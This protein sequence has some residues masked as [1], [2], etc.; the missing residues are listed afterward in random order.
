MRH[1]SSFRYVAVV[2]ALALSACSNDDVF[3]GEGGLIG[4]GGTGGSGGGGGDGTATPE[5]RIGVL[6]GT[7]FTPGVIEVGQSPLAAGGSSGLRVNIVDTANG[8][9]LVTDPVTVTF[10]SPCATGGADAAAIIDPVQVTATAGTA[11]ATYRAQG[12]DGTET[13]RATAVIDGQ[14]RTATGDITVLPAEL[15]SVQFLSASPEVIGI[16]G[17]GSGL[18]ETSVVTFR[19]VNASGGA[20]AGQEVTFSLNTTVGGI[21]LN[22]ANAT[23]TT[24]SSGAASITVQAGTVH[25]AVRVTATAQRD[26]ITISSQSSLLAVTTGTPDQDSFSLSAECFNVEALNR[27]GEVVPLTIRAA[28]RFNN[29]APDGTAVAFTTEGGAVVGNCATVDGACTVDWISQNPRPLSFCDTNT[30]VDTP[31]D[32]EDDSESSV[33]SGNGAL[34]AGRATVLATAIGEESF[35]DADGDGRFDLGESFGDLPEAFRDDDEDGLRDDGSDPNSGLV[36]EFVDFDEDATYDPANGRFT[37]VLCD[38]S[39]DP[40]AGACS[41]I[42]LHVRESLTIVMSGSSPFLRTD[43]DIAVSGM[44]FDGSTF[45]LPAAGATGF[46]AFVVRD[47]NFQ[48][49]PAGTTVELSAAEAGSVVGVSSYAVPCTTSDTQGGNAYSFAIKGSDEGGSGLVQ[50]TVTSPRGLVS[51]YSF[52]LFVPAPPPPSP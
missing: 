8:N 37:G 18:P 44:S 40:A 50:L 36:E 5:I 46:V 21:A 25:T 2:L 28:D 48:P 23:A 27:D 14:V 29:P 9:A 22:P 12:C 15:G 34:R 42:S 43:Q 38:P 26:G 3:T 51:T 49:M 32:C 30:F 11:T 45:S 24:D 13:I 16:R 7:E 35:V 4:G 20:V 47:V 52:G 31:W 17:S 19:V 10:S 6:N 41:P 1:Q 39:N 33:I